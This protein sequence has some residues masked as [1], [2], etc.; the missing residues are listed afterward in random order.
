MFQ[1][2]RNAPIQIYLWDSEDY[3]EVVQT[4]PSPSQKLQRT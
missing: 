1:S 4:N 3:G 2:I